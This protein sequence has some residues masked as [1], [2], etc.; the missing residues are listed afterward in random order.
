MYTLLKNQLELT[1]Q[2]IN[3]KYLSREKYF[4]MGILIKIL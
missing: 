1:Y 3:N 2:F 4:S